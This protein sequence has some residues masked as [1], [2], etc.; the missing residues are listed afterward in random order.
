MNNEQQSKQIQVKA[1]DEDLKGRFT[2]A[3]QV[4]RLE[5]HFLVDFFLN[6]PPVG[7]MVARL[8]MTPGQLKRLRQAVDIQLQEYEEQTGK[9]IDP[10]DDGPTIGFRA[11]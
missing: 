3:A 7:Q 6:A 9:K 1:S 10:A 4:Y 11:P 8:A 5:D 2:N